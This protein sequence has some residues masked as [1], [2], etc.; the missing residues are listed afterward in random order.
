VA[1]AL[2]S[3]SVWINSSGLQIGAPFG[4]VKQSGFGSMGGRFGLQDFLRPKNVY[5]PLS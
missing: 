2:E 3:G 1:A 5:I 4:G